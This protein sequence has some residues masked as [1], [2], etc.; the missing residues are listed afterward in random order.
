M[1]DHN[2][3]SVNPTGLLERSDILKIND[4][5]DELHIAHDLIELVMMA[6]ISEHQDA[7]T[8]GSVTA[9]SH[10]QTALSGLQAITAAWREQAS[11]A[12]DPKGEA[13]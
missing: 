5:L 2:A 3:D 9:Q 8:R 7:L 4:A 1:T 13:A 6:S 10:L 12:H 11:N